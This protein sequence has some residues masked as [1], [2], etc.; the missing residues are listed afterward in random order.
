MNW[1][2]ELGQTILHKMGLGSDQP[3]ATQKAVLAAVKKTKIEPIELPDENHVLFA[4]ETYHFLEN[5]SAEGTSVKWKSEALK[6]RMLAKFPAM[7]DSK[8]NEIVEGLYV[9]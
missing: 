1:I 4:A 7:K 5:T 6:T 2:T 9:P 8:L 3:T